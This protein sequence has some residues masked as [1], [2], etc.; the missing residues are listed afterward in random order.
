MDFLTAIMW[1]TPIFVWLAALMWISQFLA[2]DRTPAWLSWNSR[3]FISI[4]SLMFLRDDEHDIGCKWTIISSKFQFLLLLKLITSKKSCTVEVVAKKCYTTN[5]GVQDFSQHL[6]RG[7]DFRILSN[8]KLS[9]CTIQKTPIVVRRI[10][11]FGFS[12]SPWR[13]LVKMTSWSVRQS[14]L[15]SCWTFVR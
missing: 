11:S 13:H 14:Y 4:E 2:I 3:F 9:Y 6:K 15:L 7:T 1:K 10:H 5:F 8:R 12:V